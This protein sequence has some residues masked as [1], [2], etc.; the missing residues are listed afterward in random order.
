M[1]CAVSELVPLVSVTPVAV[2]AT[3]PFVGRLD[4]GVYA[5]TGHEGAGIGRGPADAVALARQL[6]DAS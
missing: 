6:L 5:I 1:T 2:R 3:G 4:S